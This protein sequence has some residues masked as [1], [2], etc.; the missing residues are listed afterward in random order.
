MAAFSQSIF[1][2]LGGF[3][4]SGLHTYSMLERHAL[5]TDRDIFRRHKSVSLMNYHVDHHLYGCFRL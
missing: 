4:L 2:L 5:E 3:A 1:L